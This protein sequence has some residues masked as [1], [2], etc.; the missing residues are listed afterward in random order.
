MFSDRVKKLIREYLLKD[1]MPVEIIYYKDSI[2]FIDREQKYWYFEYHKTDKHLWWRWSHFQSAL[3]MFSL[4][5]EEHQYL[6]GEIVSSILNKKQILECKH[7]NKVFKTVGSIINFKEE[8]KKVLNHEVE[9]TARQFL[10]KPR[11]VEKVLNCE[12]ETTYIAYEVRDIQV[13]KV[14]NREV[15]TTSA[16]I[17]IKEGRVEEVLNH[18]VETT[19]M[20]KVMEPF[21]VEQVLNNEVET[22]AFHPFNNYGAVEE[23][24]NNE[25]ETTYFEDIPQHLQV[26]KVL[27]SEVE[28]TQW[29]VAPLNN[30]V[31]ELLNH[32][33]ETADWSYMPKNSMTE[34]V[35]NHEVKTTCGGTHKWRTEMEEVLNH[36]VKTATGTGGAMQEFM[37]EEVLNYEVKTTTLAEHWKNVNWKDYQNCD[38]PPPI[39]DG[40]TYKLFEVEVEEALNHNV[41]TI[42]E[43]YHNDDYVTDEILNHTVS[44]YSPSEFLEEEKHINNVLNY[45]TDTIEI[46][47][48]RKLKGEN[49]LQDIVVS[50]ILDESDKVTDKL[51]ITE[52]ND[53]TYGHNVFM[54]DFLVQN[55]LDIGSNSISFDA[56]S[57]QGRVNGVLKNS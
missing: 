53:M 11:L 22:T 37:T 43:A 51:K 26:D 23:V 48:I 18:N 31:E 41:E 15:E 3:T 44:T 17:V 9:T 20:N 27:N 21:E 33:I 54:C 47:S 40:Y 8:V 38:T 2:W 42:G 49:P 16:Q 45:G 56:T 52:D 13:E 4:N 14:L 36:E 28:T 32:E 34:E 46:K 24:L 50:H 19:S 29:E 5:G 30:M 25:V 7:P 10:Q 12:V 39:I 57:Q 6:F 55:V 35:L 1:L